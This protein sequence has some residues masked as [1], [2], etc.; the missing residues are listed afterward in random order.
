[1]R[2]TLIVAATAV[3]GAMTLPGSASAGPI[4]C[5]AW[6]AVQERVGQ[7]IAYCIDDPN[8]TEEK[9]R[10]LLELEG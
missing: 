9:I 1:M 6:N 7:D 3:A 4:Y 8:P 5:D 10:E 2:K